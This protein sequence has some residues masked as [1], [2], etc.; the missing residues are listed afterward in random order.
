MVPSAGVVFHVKHFASG[1]RV[2]GKGR[3]AQGRGDGGADEQ[4]AFSGVVFFAQ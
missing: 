3:E 1:N 2:D 4:R